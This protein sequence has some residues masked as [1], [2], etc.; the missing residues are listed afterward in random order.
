MR[1]SA[2]AEIRLRDPVI[3]NRV[4]EHRRRIVVRCNRCHGS[5]FI[6]NGH[7]LP[8]ACMRE[9]EAYKNILISGAPIEAYEILQKIQSG[10]R[11]TDVDFKR[12]EMSTER[13]DIHETSHRK[14]LYKNLIKPYVGHVKQ[15]LSGGDSI[16]LFGNN[17]RGKTWALYF[18]LIKLMS[19]Y[20]VLFFNLKDL[21][22]L[23]NSALYGSDN[24]TESAKDKAESK[25]I[26]NLVRDVDILLLDE[27]SKLPKFSDHVSVQLEGIVK[28][29]IGNRRPVVMATNHSPTEFHVNFGSQVVSAF[30]KNVYS[31]HIL[32]GPDLRQI[33]MRQSHAFDYLRSQ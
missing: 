28:D 20:S 9:F 33:A 1:R 19:K 24:T 29:R 31:A 32:N 5:G 14:K 12:V 22:T 18:I 11:L 26:L 23:I 15:A 2:F 17:S 6:R 25:A 8:C 27:G 13:H 4:L 16:L 21:F 3:Y 30:I 10:G 7:G